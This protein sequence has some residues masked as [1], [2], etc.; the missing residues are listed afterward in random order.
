[1]S[2]VP[3]NITFIWTYLE[4]NSTAIVETMV[5][6]MALFLKNNSDDSKTY[7]NVGSYL[8][9]VTSVYLVEDKEH[10]LEVLLLPPPRKADAVKSE[11][12]ST[13]VN[14]SRFSLEMDRHYSLIF[15]E[16]KTDDDMFDMMEDDGL[17][18]ELKKRI[19]TL[20]CLTKLQKLRQRQVN[21][22]AAI[23]EMRIQ[24]LPDDGNFKA[25][26]LFVERVI[27]QLNNFYI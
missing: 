15:N 7:I 10:W 6:E 1:M 27:D 17:F 12:E 20:E 5:D 8:L 18:N 2:L 21:A 19:P 16:K 23:Q 3:L 9:V 26:G 25:L 14:K 13:H 22:M 24:A 4:T 11:I